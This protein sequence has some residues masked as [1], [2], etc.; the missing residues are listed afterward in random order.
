MA[1]TYGSA[2]SLDRLA[3]DSIKDFQVD[4]AVRPSL[5]LEVSALEKTLVKID[6]MT[7]GLMYHMHLII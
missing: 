7:V 5:P 2:Y 1:F 4:M 3:L 6:N